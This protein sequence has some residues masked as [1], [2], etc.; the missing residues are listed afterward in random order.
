MTKEQWLG[1]RQDFDRT[2]YALRQLRK[3]IFA[4]VNGI[5][6]GGL[7]DRP[8]HRLHHLVDAATFGQPEAMLG[9]AA[10]G[11][12]PACF[13]ACYHRGRRSGCR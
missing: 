10:G 3:P 6:H 4:A 5:A 1:Q 11:G 13:P 7:R 8:E 12:S 9:L 2:L